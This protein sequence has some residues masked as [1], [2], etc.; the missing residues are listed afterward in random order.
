LKRWRLQE[1]PKKSRDPA[2]QKIGVPFFATRA[3]ASQPRRPGEWM[4]KISFSA[5]R[6]SQS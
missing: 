2:S 5:D 1:E 6:G 4:G 3:E